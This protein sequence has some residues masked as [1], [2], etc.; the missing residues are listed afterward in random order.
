MSIRGRKPRPP[1]LK[2][3]AGERRDRINPNPPAKLDGRPDPPSYL[4]ELGRAEWDRIVPELEAVGCLSRAD[5]AA[6]GLYCASHSQM[7]LAEREVAMRGML[8]DTADG[9]VKPNPA[10]GMARNARL[11]CGRFLVEFGLTPSARSR[12][13]TAAN[14]GPKDELS[15]FL[16]TGDIACGS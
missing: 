11:V 7:V 2:I 5:G 10:V 16:T 6:L 13:K 15:A 8:V 9:G 14:D 4:D 12:V 3:L 1:E